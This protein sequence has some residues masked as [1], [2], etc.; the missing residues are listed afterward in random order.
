MLSPRFLRPRDLLPQLSITQPDYARRCGFPVLR[1]AKET[2]AVVSLNSGSGVP[3]TFGRDLQTYLQ[4]FHLPQPDLSVS[5]L[6]GASHAYRGNA[7]GADTE[8]A[9]DV[10][11]ILGVTGG[12]VNVRVYVAPNTEQ[13]VVLALRQILADK[14]C[15]AVSMSWGLAE[16]RWTAAGRQAIDAAALALVAAGIPCFAASGDAGSGDGLPGNNA[17]SPAC[18]PYWIACGGT[19]NA[20]STETAWSY[21][22]G[23]YSQ[24]YGRPLWQPTFLGNWRGEPDVAGNA[25]SNSGF[26]VCVGG[27]W[28]TIGGTSAVA[29]VWAAAYASAVS[30]LGRRIPN[31]AAWLYAHAGLFTDIVTGT[32]GAYKARGGWDECTGLGTLNERLFAALL[33]AAL[34]PPP[35]PPVVSNGVVSKIQLL[36]ALG[37]V[38]HSFNV[39]AA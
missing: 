13:G 9:L 14:I 20:T 18:S 1:V 27:V 21:G 7:A 26:P 4:H 36:D 8:D 16:S 35:P 12:T 37:G 29:P 24:L 33:T 10:Q 31:F 15:C 32:N 25:D 11:N 30:A 23:G 3:G 2:V 34:P 39:T 6:P 5:E 38:L 28:K 22:G 19:S 17:D